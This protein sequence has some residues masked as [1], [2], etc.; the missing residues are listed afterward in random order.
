MIYLL[1]YDLLIY[2]KSFK[3]L[4]MTGIFD[5]YSIEWGIENNRNDNRNK[6]SYDDYDSSNEDHHQSKR[7]MLKNDKKGILPKYFKLENKMIYSIGTEIHFTAAITKETIETIIKKITKII[8]KN[9]EKYQDW[10]Q[11]NEKLVITYVVDSPGGCVNSILKFV[12]Y[13]NLVRAKHPYVEFVS[14]ITGLV[15]SAGTIMCVVA[16]KRFMTPYSHAMI[17]ELSSGNSGKYTHFISYS[18]FLSSLHE[19]LLDIYLQH[20]NKEKDELEDLLKTE[21]W[22]NAPEYMR[23]GFVDEIK[24]FYEKPK[25]DNSN[26]ESSSNSK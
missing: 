19:T 6:R 14:V 20:T 1:Y 13:L 2:N 5:P 22:F 4:E 25:E 12:D 7:R 18:K 9:H 11:G 15:A 17:H 26:S 3:K 21:T 23:H 24:G 10:K 16:D 8:D